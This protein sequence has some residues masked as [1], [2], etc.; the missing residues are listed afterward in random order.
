MP[1]A[2]ISTTFPDS[3]LTGKSN[4]VFV[5]IVVAFSYAALA[6]FDEAFASAGGFNQTLAI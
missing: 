1:T 4:P 6:D 5:K 2:S 3:Y